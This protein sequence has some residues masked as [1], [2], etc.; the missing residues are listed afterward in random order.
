[1][2]KYYFFRDLDNQANLKDVKTYHAAG[3]VNK[4]YSEVETSN[5]KDLEVTFFEPFE[6]AVT[7][8]WRAHSE[9]ELFEVNEQ[10]YNRLDHHF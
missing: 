5:G 1:M 3:I 9:V 4:V 7:N 10:E 8:A 2:K 6:G